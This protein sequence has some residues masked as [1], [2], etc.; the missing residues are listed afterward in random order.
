M[1]KRFT[2]VMLVLLA[3]ITF[4]KEKKCSPWLG[5]VSKRAIQKIIKHPNNDCAVIDL[6]IT[7][8]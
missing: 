1:S 8:S 7:F 5:Y 3:T 4:A 2:L 6:S